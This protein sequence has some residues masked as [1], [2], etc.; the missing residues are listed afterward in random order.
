MSNNLLP[1][2]TI[3][4]KLQIPEAYLEPIGKYGAKIRLE[5]LADPGF[6]RRGKMILVT[7]TT[8]TASGEGKTVTSIGLTQ[9]LERIGRRAIITSREPSLGPVFGMKG[10]AAGGGMSQIEPSQKI[11]LHFHGDFHAITTAH[12][13]L[14]AL[15][16]AHLFHGN[17]LD[18]DPEHITWPRAMDM[19]DRALR[20]ITVGIEKNSP[21]RASGFVITAA[22]EVMAVM[23]LA[24]S[25]ADLRRRLD[26]IVVGVSRGGKPIRT[27]D[28]GATGAMMA[29]LDEA[30]LPNLVQTTEGTPAMVHTGPFGNI[31]HG[32][33]SVISQQMGTRLADYVVNEAGFAADLGAEKYM[34]IVRRSL[35]MNPSVAVLVTTVQSLRNQGEGD[36]ERGLPNLGQHIKILK[37][38]GLPV[39]VAL[40]KFPTNTADELQR[41]ADFCGEHGVE[42]ATHEAYAKGGPG[43]V[44]L[45]EKVVE[46]I[47]K[48]PNPV[49]RSVY[50]LDDSL[51]GKVE[52]VAHGVYGAAGVQFSERAR[53]KLQ[54]FAEWGFA[55]LPVCIAKTQYSLSDNPKLLGAPTGWQLNVTDASLSA[56]A[57]FVVVIAGNMMLMPGLPKVSRAAS[58]DVTDSGEIIGV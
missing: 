45:A 36:L 29:L 21:G 28:L 39:V 56:G 12:N 32:T 49:I 22:S 40:N 51:A 16:D 23:A 1:I 52:K 2:Q 57:G 20:R 18:L 42:H 30:L 58:V 41:M 14:A 13:L 43:A 34:D 11:N 26:A 44:A 33:S 15:L 25:R 9:G 48:N 46:T 27:A 35:G 38:F 17:A 24:S 47:E 6:P 37:G 4:G 50:E 7:A 55:K 8:P 31:A 10:G 5:L 19:N 53:K 3:A 54:Q